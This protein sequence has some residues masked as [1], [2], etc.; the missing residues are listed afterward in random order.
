MAPMPSHQSESQPLEVDVHRVDL[1][2]ADAG[3]SDEVVLEQTVTSGVSAP[4]LWAVAVGVLALIGGSSWWLQRGSEP[5]G[6]AIPEAT[7]APEFVPGNTAARGSGDDSPGLLDLEFSVLDPAD[8]ASV[9]DERPPLDLKKIDPR[10][11]WPLFADLPDLLL[12]VS[13]PWGAIR[14]IDADTGDALTE[15]RQPV[16]TSPPQPPG[17]QVWPP[18]G[19]IGDTLV[20]QDGTSVVG[21]SLGNDEWVTYG[22]AE[23]VVLT[24]GLVILT[25]TPAEGN[26][27]AVVSAFTPDG[28]NVGNVLEPAFRSR[29]IDATGYHVGPDGSFVFTGE[30]YEKQSENTIVASGP[31]H[32]LEVRCAAGP[33]CG[34]HR[35]DLATWESEL[36]HVG[37]PFDYLGSG[38]SPDGQ[39]LS[40]FAI[41]PRE[42]DENT[43]DRPYV[44][45]TYRL[46]HLDTGDHV[47]ISS[48]R[49]A[50]KTTDLAPAVWDPT[51]RYAVI[52]QSPGLLIVDV[53]SKEVRI[54]DAGPSP[55]NP[56]FGNHVLILDRELLENG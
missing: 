40:T 41:T 13:T 35:I 14:F 5:E 42:S 36:V 34:F 33:G 23:D 24:E 18:I 12:A 3:S 16:R 51:G 39:W 6:I 49:A 26:G 44:D 22:E 56:G 37:A 10:P 29:P 46:L 8:L 25:S 43:S 32:L 52:A 38:I 19:R 53:A 55:S 31:N 2:A 50:D 47:E 9:V 28:T 21:Y 27:S 1:Q 48:L 11:A 17:E 45:I 20:M 4:A 54:V 15:R 30:S 7:V